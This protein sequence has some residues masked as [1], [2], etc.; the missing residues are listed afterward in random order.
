MYY[1][2]GLYEGG[3]SQTGAFRHIMLYENLTASAINDIDA[4]T[5]ALSLLGHRIENSITSVAQ[6]S[7][8]NVI[9]GSVRGVVTN[10]TWSGG[11]A[12]LTIVMTGAISM[13]NGNSVLVE[14]IN[15][16]GY[17]GP[18]TLT[19]SPTVTTIAYAVTPNPGTYVPGTG[20]VLLST[21]GVAATSHVRIGAN[22][23]AVGN[24]GGPGTSGVGQHAAFY[25]NGIADIIAFNRILTVEE[26]QLLEGW[27]SQRYRYN[28]I[29]GATSVVAS[30]TYRITGASYTGSSAP[31][32]ITVTY[33][34]SLVFLRS[35]Q[36][37]ISG[38]TESGNTGLNGI[39][40]VTAS[41]ATSVSFL[42]RTI[43]LSGASVTITSNNTLVGTTIG[44]SSIHPYRLNPTTIAGQNTLS[45]TSTTSTYA[46]N[47]VAWFDAANPNLINNLTLPANGTPATNNTAVTL[48][49]PT[50]GWWA[51]TPLQL[52]NTGTATYHSTTAGRTQ[53]GLGGIY[54]G[55][56]TNRLSLATGAFTQYTTINAN[57]NF[58]WTVVFR[59]DSV[60]ATTPVL[61]VTNGNSN[62]LMLCS[63][64]TFVYSSDGTAP[65]TQTVAPSV[66]LS[67]AKTHMI[68]VYRDGATVGFRIV[69]ED[70]AIGYS[71]STSTQTNLKIPTFSTPTLTFGSSTVESPTDYRTSFTGSI[72][73]AALF[74]SAMSTQAIQQIEG[75]LA[76]KWGLQA[77]LPTSHAYKRVPA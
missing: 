53:N 75:Y 35:T 27:I 45:L 20:T 10:A 42:S 65:N 54:I 14:G 74:R 61:S 68:T 6:Q 49:A 38:V 33:A 12:T 55:G 71:A 47:L 23:A 34:S 59:P 48:W 21:P 5:T 40:A 4:Q 30:P 37:T 39:W 46:Q 44:N 70:V 52:A 25:Q 66:L 56:S 32:T 16:S 51:N 22:I 9:T 3:T 24:P 28:S 15:P 60:S 69:S 73:E 31:Y 13:S 2:S 64:G 77:S 76:W 11:T 36:I 72:F 8:S 41:N 17:N 43:I 50:S 67:N 26:R 62:R 19:G 1:Q 58:T 18:F 7:T 57:N 29:M 63:N